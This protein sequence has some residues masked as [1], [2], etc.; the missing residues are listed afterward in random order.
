[1]APP[2]G[3]DDQDTQYRSQTTTAARTNL[4][5]HV[6]TFWGKPVWI[7]TRSTIETINATEL[8][9]SISIDHAVIPRPVGP[10]VDVLHQFSF[11]V[12][13]YA[14]Y[15]CNFW[16]W[17]NG[18]F[19]QPNACG[20]EAF[21]CLSTS[22][23]AGFTRS[24]LQSTLLSY[25]DWT[26]GVYIP[27]TICHLGLCGQRW[28]AMMWPGMVIPRALPPVPPFRTAFGTI[29]TDM[30]ARPGANIINH[31]INA[32]INAHKRNKYTSCA[33]IPA[34]V[35]F[36]PPSWYDAW[37]QWHGRVRSPSDCKS[38]VHAILSEHLRAMLNHMRFMRLSMHAQSYAT[39]TLRRLH[40]RRTHASHG[41]PP[42]WS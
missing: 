36:I 31:I 17:C 39:S 24:L 10:L 6:R 9:E 2:L 33:I 30:D 12:R 23:L 38:Y 40:K 25:C 41:S 1:M 20:P 27:V 37:R 11:T 35:N 26:I 16:L 29:L 34:S 19:E 22:I 13:A 21:M 18:N 3:P 4:N 42:S 28:V 5:A 15:E 14:Y 7:T 32:H 8:I